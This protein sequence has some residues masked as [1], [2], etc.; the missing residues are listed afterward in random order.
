MRCRWATTI[1]GSPHVV[2]WGRITRMRYL[3][4]RNFVIAAAAAPI[5]EMTTGPRTVVVIRKVDAAIVPWIA[6]SIKATSR[7]N[8]NQR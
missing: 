1:G 7:L 8:G 4:E 3:I 6:I 5:G 2:F